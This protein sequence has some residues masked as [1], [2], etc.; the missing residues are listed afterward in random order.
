MTEPLKMPP[1]PCVD[2]VCQTTGNVVNDVLRMLHNRIPDDMSMQLVAAMAV[3]ACLS[4]EERILPSG[5]F[6]LLT[7]QIQSI[8]ARL[9]H[10]QLEQHDETGQSAPSN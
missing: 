4:I 8:T 6:E 3:V 10:Q 7:E 1:C 9:I 5:L 2:P